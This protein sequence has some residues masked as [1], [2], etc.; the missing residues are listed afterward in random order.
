MEDGCGDEIGDLGGLL[1]R[2]AG[3]VAGFECVEGVET[4]LLAG[5]DLFGV[6]RILRTG[7]GV[8]LRDAGV[9]IPAVEVDALIGLEE[10]SEELAGGGE[11][12]S[13]E[14]DEAYDYVCD[15][16]AGVVDVVLYA[17]FVA[18]LVAVGAEEALEGVAEDG[19]AKVP[20]VGGF[21]GVDAGVFDEAEAGA[22]DLRVLIG[23]YAADSGGSVEADVEVAG[24]CDL[25]AGDAFKFGLS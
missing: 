23:C 15:L 1:F 16:H 14:V 7:T 13:F 20:D 9:E 6:G 8:P 11:I 2:A 3:A 19:V 12:F 5:G 22:A 17:Y 25:D 21:V 24:S 18:A 4:D 10:F